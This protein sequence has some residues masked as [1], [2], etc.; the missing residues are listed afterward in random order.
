MTDQKT[1]AGLGDIAEASGTLG[2]TV[3]LD[4]GGNMQTVLSYTGTGQVPGALAW[5]TGN[6]TGTANTQILQP[7]MTVFG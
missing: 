4:V 7:W 6:F 2:L 3:Y 1:L 5:V